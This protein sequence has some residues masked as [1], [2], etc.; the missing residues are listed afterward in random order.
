MHKLHICFAMILKKKTRYQELESMLKKEIQHGNL[1]VG[2]YLP[3]EN[4][5][6]TNFSITRTTVRK[7]LDN[8]L[9]EAYIE[10][11]Q[12]KGNRVKEHRNSLGLVIPD[13]KQ[14]SFVNLTH[15]L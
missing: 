12:G 4:E 9:K 3:S 8:L 1:Q 14:L 13:W 7:A 11:L 6:C 10:K 2:D 15:N 5:L